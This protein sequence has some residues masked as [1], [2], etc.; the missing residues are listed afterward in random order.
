MTPLIPLILDYIFSITITVMYQN[1]IFARM[2]YVSV[3]LFFPLNLVL[4]KVSLI[5]DLLDYHF[6]SVMQHLLSYISLFLLNISH[7]TYG[8]CSILESLEPTTLVLY[9]P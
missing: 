1:Y 3:P 6:I 2:T 7:Y 9:I 4:V 8:L 5:I